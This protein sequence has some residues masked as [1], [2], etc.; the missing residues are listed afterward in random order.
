MSNRSKFVAAVLGLLV[1]AIIAAWQLFLFAMLRDPLGLLD[2]Q[3]GR[4]HLWL[5]VSASFAACLAGAL[6]FYFF[7]HRERNKWPNLS[8]ASIEPPLT[9]DSS[10]NSL[11]G[12]PFNRVRWMQLNPW[13]SEGQADDRIPMNGSVAASSG[14]PSAQRAFARRSHQLRFKAWS[15]ARHD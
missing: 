11:P 14:T 6:M 15:Q 5:G 10:T 1:L 8:T 3:G 2:S 13:L 12:V 7:L 9:A 4:N